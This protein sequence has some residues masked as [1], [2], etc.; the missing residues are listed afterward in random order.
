MLSD[1]GK[2]VERRGRKAMDLRPVRALTARLPKE[3]RSGHSATE[4]AQ[5]LCG[6]VDG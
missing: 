2:P 4:V 5:R 3:A 6:G 1:K